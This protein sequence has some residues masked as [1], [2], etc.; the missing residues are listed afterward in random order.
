MERPHFEVVPFETL[1][2]DWSIYKLKDG[3]TV[4]IRYILINVL[5]SPQLDV[6]GN[7]TYDLNYGTIAGVI[8]DPSLRGPPSSP[9]SPEVLGKSIVEKDIGFESVAEPWNEYRVEGKKLKIKLILTKIARTS[10]F[11]EHG[12][13]AY[14]VNTQPII[15]SE[16]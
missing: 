5:K 11:T 12:D 14:L 6:F 2:E 4:K 8:S 3:S 15:T 13:P 9:A 7:P 10:V 1:K 16:G